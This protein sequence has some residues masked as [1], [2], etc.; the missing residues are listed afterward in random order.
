MGILSDRPPTPGGPVTGGFI[1]TFTTT[2]VLQRQSAQAT[3]IAT[4]A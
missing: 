2:I 4:C 3:Y 1:F